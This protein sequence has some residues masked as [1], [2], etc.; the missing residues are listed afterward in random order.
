MLTGARVGN[1]A[2]AEG[3]GKRTNGGATFVQF[4]TINAPI[5]TRYRFGGA[6]VVESG[7]DI[8]DAKLR[9]Q[10]QA[11]RPRV[12]DAL[13]AAVADFAQTR[14]RAGASPNVEVMSGV[15]QA[16]VDKVVGKPGGA[17]LLLV[18]VMVQSPR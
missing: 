12:Q 3:G 15:M 8:P 16:A 18:S 4:A 13:R 17:K 10:V 5:A 14:Y 9:A 2:A 11:L 1:A 7:L 6:L